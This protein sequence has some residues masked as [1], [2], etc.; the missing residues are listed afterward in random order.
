MRLWAPCM[1]PCRYGPPFRLPQQLLLGS[2]VLR[3]SSPYQTW[4]DWHLMPGLHLQEFAYD[5]SDLEQRV[6]QQLQSDDTTRDVTTI[7]LQGMAHAAR[8]LVAA[9]VQIVAQ[10]D[11]FAWSVARYKEVC[12]WEV[13]RPS[14]DGTAQWH[15]LQL[16]ADVF[17]SK[18]V[19]EGVQAQ[20]MQHLHTNFERALRHPAAAAMPRH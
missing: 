9:K 19:P 13:V 8:A 4:L 11:A 6:L 14:G 12:R 5:L 2:A 15:V 3:M 1:Q 7:T 10:L 20:V 16:G 18:G 17:Q